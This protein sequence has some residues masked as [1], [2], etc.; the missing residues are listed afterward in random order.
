[1]LQRD[2]R[3][4]LS[5]ALLIAASALAAQTPADAPRYRYFMKRDSETG[6]ET[7]GIH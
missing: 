1:M 5:I 3:V 2:F 6:K 7:D 4:P